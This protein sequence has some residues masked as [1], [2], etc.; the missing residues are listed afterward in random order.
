MSDDQNNP[1]PNQYESPSQENEIQYRRS[2]NRLKV[3]IIFTLMMIILAVPAVMISNQ[4]A[5]DLA[6][7]AEYREK[8]AAK[9]G[10][11]T[12]T[13]NESPK[14]YEGYAANGLSEIRIGYTWTDKSSVKFSIPTGTEIA[15]IDWTNSEKKYGHD[16]SLGKIET[17]SLEYEKNIN[18]VELKNLFISEDQ[19]ED[20]DMSIVLDDSTLYTIYSHW[21]SATEETV[22]NKTLRVIDLS[23]DAG[24]SSV[25]TLMAFYELD[26]SNYLLINSKTATVNETN[27][28]IIR[29]L[30]KTA[31]L[32][33]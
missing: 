10:A 30:V 17:K 27:L 8:Y 15:R 21:R 16:T 24:A 29:S 19:S 13:D 4:H 28:Q 31:E 26:K 20:T 5:K 33:D 23:G 7:E 12:E 18:A 1:L 11:T 32:L 6:K 2:S 9:E 3:L 14:E 22:D 25:F